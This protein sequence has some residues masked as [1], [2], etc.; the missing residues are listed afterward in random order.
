LVDELFVLIAAALSADQLHPRP[1]LGDRVIG[2]HKKRSE[3]P[4]A[5]D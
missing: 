5:V 2:F 4:G 3:L 1:G